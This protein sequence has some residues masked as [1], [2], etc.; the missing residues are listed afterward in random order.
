[1]KRALLPLL[2][3]AATCGGCAVVAVAD[4][5]VTTVATVATTAVKAAGAVIDAVIP[6]SKP[7]KRAEP[8][9]ATPKK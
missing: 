3:L 5:A 1:M 8:T 2:F 7:A 9:Q 4:F 6:D